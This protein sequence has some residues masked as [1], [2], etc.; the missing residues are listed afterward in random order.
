M[1]IILRMTAPRSS[2]L[3]VRNVPLQL[4]RALRAESRRRKKSL[5]QT[6]IDLLGQATGVG[7]QGATPNGLQKLAGTWSGQEFEE[8]EAAL[9]S[10]RNIDP[11][12]WQ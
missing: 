2:H 7:E 8:F 9:A 10:A 1:H 12:L 4:A 3:T 11:E 6:V 5:N